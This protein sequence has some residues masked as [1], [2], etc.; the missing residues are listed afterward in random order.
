M[1]AVTLSTRLVARPDLLACD[2]GTDGA[3]L[4]DPRAGLYLGLEG[5]AHLMWSRL[6]T[7]P[8]SLAS[9]CAS[10]LEEYE[11]TADVCEADA[12]AFIDD[13]LR[14]ELVTIVDGD[15]VSHGP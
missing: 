8:V 5:P 12:R 3:V 6:S 9:L 13:L 2:V 7:G 10:V 15:V 1:P 14:R 11:V 4:L